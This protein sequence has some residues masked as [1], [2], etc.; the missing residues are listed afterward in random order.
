MKTMTRTALAFIA[1]SAAI[2]G[3]AMA[4][5]NAAPAPQAQ[6]DMKPGR[7]GP[8]ARFDRMDT[9]SNGTISFEEFAAMMNGRIGDADA[10]KDGE[11]TVEEIAT[12]IENRRAE[13]MAQRMIA[14]FD[15]DGDGKLMVSE[16]ENRQKKM[17]AM[18]DRNDDGQISKEEMPRRMGKGGHGE[19]GEHRGGHRWGH[20]GGGDRW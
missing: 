17:F 19:R 6:D 5:D 3:S 7:G 16:I 14:R 18:M 2:G 11:L 12:A 20:H 8:G 13:R 10:N 9:D 4:Q 1:L 15:N